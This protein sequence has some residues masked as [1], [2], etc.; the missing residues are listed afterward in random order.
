MVVYGKSPAPRRRPSSALRLSLKDILGALSPGLNLKPALRA[1][2]LGTCR[3]LVLG[4]LYLPPSLRPSLGAL[5]LRH[6][7]ALEGLILE[8]NLVLVGWNWGL[9]PDLIPGNLGRQRSLVVG[10]PVLWPRLIVGNLVMWPRL[11]V[12]NLRTQPGLVIGNLGIWPGL[13]IRNLEMWPGPIVGKP[14]L[15]VG[16]VTWD[17]LRFDHISSFR[18]RIQSWKQKISDWHKWNSYFVIFYLRC[19][20]SHYA[21]V[22]HFTFAWSSPTE[23]SHGSTALEKNTGL[24]NPVSLQMDTAIIWWHETVP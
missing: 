3:K 17:L 20:L 23:S 10:N 5:T 21:V 2:P 6:S 13:I 4:I 8:F 14:E 22:L 9:R 19:S 18:V 12:G 1:L 7:T 11:I 16:L 15:K 24:S